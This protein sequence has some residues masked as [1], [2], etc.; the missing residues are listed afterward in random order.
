MEY[1]RDKIPE[2][3]TKIAFI[4]ADIRFADPLWLDKVSEALEK[5]SVIQPMDYSYRDITNKRVSSY[6]IS[7][8]NF[9]PSVAKGICNKEQMDIS[10]HYPGFSVCIRRDF[11][12]KI[13]GFLNMA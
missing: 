10:K 6:S 8:D 12:R 9:R 3:F 11:L 5:H 1:T 4:D 2:Q 7:V 13:G